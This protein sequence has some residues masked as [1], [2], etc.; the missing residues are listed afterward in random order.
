MSGER[1]KPGALTRRRNHNIPVLFFDTTL[2]DGE[3]SPGGSLAPPQKSRIAHQLARLGVDVIEAGFP[4]S[5]RGDFEAVQMVAREVRGPVI[6]GLAR[7]VESDIRSCWEAVREASRPRIHTFVSTSD[8]HLECQMGMS[9]EE[10]LALTRRMV[11]LAVSLCPS[12][13]QFS[14]MDATRSDIDFLAA[15]LRAAIEVGATTVNLSDTV[16]YALPY[17]Y[18][19]LVD[20][21]HEKV[22]RLDE[23]AMSVHCH[24]DLGLA[25]ANSLAAIERG[26]MQVEVAVNGLGERAGV[27]ALEEVAMALITREQAFHRPCNIVTREIAATSHLVSTLTGLAV[28]AN[29][30][31]VGVNAFAHESGIHQDGVM[32]KRATYEIMRPEDVGLE[33]H[34]IVLGKHSGRSALR[35]ALGAMGI[36]LG[37]EQLD[38]VFFRFKN[39]ADTRKEIA[40]G[41]IRSLAL[42]I[43]MV[44]NRDGAEPRCELRAMAPVRD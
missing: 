43:E 1:S 22:P 3:Q 15:V 33:G 11:A 12:D 9:R 40:L 37:P 14:A 44:Q 26:I 6:S 24:N 21:L 16:G 32:K 34:R 8:V 39:L 30:A 19:D 23:V 25:T 29:K 38:E 20:R 41:D 17:E 5:S 42:E 27:A 18:A 35:S 31:V 4:A 2:R 7:C 28:Q 36:R 13:V 10:V